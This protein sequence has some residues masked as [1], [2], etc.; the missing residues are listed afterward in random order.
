[1]TDQEQIQKVIQ[2][3]KQKTERPPRT[4]NIVFRVTPE[5]RDRL[6]EVFG[7]MSGIRD[8]ALASTDTVIHELD[9]KTTGDSLKV[10]GDADQG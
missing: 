9:I 5:E 1:M 4:E 2:A 8:Y 6:L 10:D 3:Y 7:S